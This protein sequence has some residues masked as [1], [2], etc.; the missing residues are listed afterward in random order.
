MRR[1]H[2]PTSRLTPDL[3]YQ[4]LKVEKLINYVMERGKKNTAR[5]IVYGALEV[6]KEKMKAE[7]IEIFEQAIN[8]VG[9]QME[10]RS[11]RVGGANY[12]VPHE[13]RP[14]RRLSLGLRW[15]IDSAKAK[16]GR[17][18]IDRL[19]DE[20]VNASKNEGDAVKKKE[21]VHKMAEANR[22]FAHFAVA[23]RK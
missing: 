6:V 17:P 10:V 1:K 18:M 4:N 3:I 5:K 14:E 22:A 11:R 8:N 9:P 2:K 23:R 20:I 19:A 21:N 15:I 7:P 16:S 12:Q 13:V